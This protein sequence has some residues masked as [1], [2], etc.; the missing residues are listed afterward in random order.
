MNAWVLWSDYGQDGG[1]EIHRVYLTKTRADEDFALVD[2][3]GF[4]EWHL[5][6]APIIDVLPDKQE[7][8]SCSKP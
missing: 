2:H 7:T 5:S 6:E 8:E 1:G 4:K 3:N